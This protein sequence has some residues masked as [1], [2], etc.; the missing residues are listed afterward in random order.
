M[1]AI[2]VDDPFFGAIAAAAS[3]YFALKGSAQAETVL[4]DEEEIRA[5]NAQQ[6][7]I[8]AVTDVLSFPSV[9]F[10]AGEYPPFTAENF[11]CDID[12]E[13]GC[14]QLGSI[15]IC[16]QTAER[17]A[18]EYGHSVEREK[19]YLF[20]HGLLHLLGFDHMTDA[21][22]KKMRTAEEAILQSLNISR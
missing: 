6:R 22:K 14:V 4:C 21:D 13:N 3:D 9:A 7:G 2:L 8:D 20:L 18:A 15:L 5:V 10:T 16:E 1:S 11:P 12:P 17:Q 19:G